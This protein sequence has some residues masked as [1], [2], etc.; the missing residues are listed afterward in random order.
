VDCGVITIATEGSFSEKQRAPEKRI[1]EIMQW[2]A[3]AEVTVE[4]RQQLLKENEEIEM[5]RA[6]LQAQR[7][8]IEEQIAKVN[9]EI[10]RQIQGNTVIVELQKM[11]DLQMRNLEIITKQSSASVVAEAQEKLTRARIELAKQRE[12]IGNSAG[13]GRI[14]SFNGQL[15]DIMI[16]LADSQAKQ[17][18]LTEQ[19]E[20]TE[21][22]LAAGAKFDPEAS[23]I[24]SAKQ[25]FDIAE[26]RVSKLKSYLANLQEPTVLVVGMN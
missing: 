6:S 8:A 21:K 2:N 15:S 7:S 25:E 22:Q 9:K 19:L 16:R 3:P 10:D 20:Q 5:T 11:V 17:G 13:G 23:Q 18:V 14:A 4:R 1:L 26:G 24:R 12:E